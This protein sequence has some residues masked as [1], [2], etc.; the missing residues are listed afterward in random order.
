MDGLAYH[1]LDALVQTSVPTREIIGTRW[2]ELDL[3][4]DLLTVPGSRMKKRKDHTEPQRAV[5]L[6]QA[7][8]A[9]AIWCSA[10]WTMTPCA[11]RWPR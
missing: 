10:I 9:A 3:E 2:S 6:F 7:S 4:R 1:C 5:A 8:H 11:M